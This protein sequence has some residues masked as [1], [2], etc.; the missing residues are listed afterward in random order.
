M[1]PFVLPLVVRQKKVTNGEYMRSMAV[2]S[3]CMAPGGVG[4]LSPVELDL[5]LVLVLVLAL[6]LVLELV[7]ALVL[8]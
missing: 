2:R 8:V 6:V 4:G 3:S 1:L 5:A 7:L